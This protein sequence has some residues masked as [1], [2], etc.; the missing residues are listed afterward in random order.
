MLITQ[1]KRSKCGKS[2]PQP[3]GMEQTVTFSSRPPSWEAV[4]DHLAARGYVVQMRMIDGE[5]ALPDEM[6]PDEWRELR[7][8][9]PEGMVTIRRT[10]GRLTLIT[11]GN[12]DAG[13][14]QAWNALTWAFAAL[15]DGRIE[16]PGGVLDAESYRQQA[17][18]PAAL[19]GRPD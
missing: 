8:G 14:Q 15:G 3:M 10:P 2:E 7:I 4:R 9:A 18:L 11:W 5:L 17:T 12:A 6:P 1:Q 19:A 13:L 16:T